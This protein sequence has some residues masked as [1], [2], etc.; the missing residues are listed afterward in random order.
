MALVLGIAQQLIQSGL[1][2][3]SEN[4]ATSLDWDPNKGPLPSSDR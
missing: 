4:P 2:F 1:P 3:D